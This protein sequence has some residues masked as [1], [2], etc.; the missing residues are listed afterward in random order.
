MGLFKQISNLF[1]KRKQKAKQGKV[2]V[3]FKLRQQVIYPAD[4]VEELG[5]AICL[6][7]QKEVC[8]NSN[9]I[10][11]YDMF[12]IDNSGFVGSFYA[13]EYADKYYGYIVG[14]NRIISCLKTSFIF[15][16]TD[17]MTIPLLRTQDSYYALMCSYQKEKGITTP[18]FLKK[19]ILS[20]FSEVICINFD[21]NTSFS[22]AFTACE[23]FLK[24]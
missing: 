8:L 6:D 20:D 18:L 4:V 13:F 10:K 22:F 5:V 24:G 7:N 23:K 1:S 12:R 3:H 21:K 17:K 2:C 19:V 16:E 9:D 11:L 14:D 15:K